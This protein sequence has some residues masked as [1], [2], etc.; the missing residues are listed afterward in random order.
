MLLNMYGSITQM[1][2]IHR[3]NL[4]GHIVL[5]YIAEKLK[6]IIGIKN[7]LLNHIKI[8][9]TKGFYKI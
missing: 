5:F 3:K 9:Q 8:R 1:S 2:V 6:T 7:T 4:H